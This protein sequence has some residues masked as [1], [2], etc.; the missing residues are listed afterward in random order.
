MRWRLILEEFG[1]E[2]IYLPGKSNVVADAL[3][4]LNSSS[5]EQEQTE[6]FSNQAVRNAELFG[7]TKHD[8]AA[9]CY[10]LKYSTL[11]RAQQHDKQLKK[12][13]SSSDHYCFHTFCGVGTS[14]TLICYKEKIVIPLSLKNE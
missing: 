1:P 14:R 5:V 9:D 7:Q 3:S 13:M 12:M 11:Q 2:I 8:I 6:T 4:R 10:P